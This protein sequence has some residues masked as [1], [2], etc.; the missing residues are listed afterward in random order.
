MVAQAGIVDSQ[1][2]PAGRN[3]TSSLSPE[4]GRPLLEVKCRAEERGGGDTHWL[5][6]SF[7][8]N[9]LPR[10]SIA[11]APG[12]KRNWGTRISVLRETQQSWDSARLQ[13]PPK[14][15]LG[16]GQDYV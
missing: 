13:Q 6:P 14:E 9:L 11:G 4:A 10:P 2:G 15:K 1:A 12:G 8:S 7:Q 5:F 3:V 16:T